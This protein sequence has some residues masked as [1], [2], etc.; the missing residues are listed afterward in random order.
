MSDKKISTTTPEKL[1]RKRQIRAQ[2]KLEGRCTRCGGK[3]DP[4]YRCKPCRNAELMRSYNMTLEQ[5]ETMSDDQGGCC[6]LCRVVF[7]AKKPLQRM[8]VDHNHRTGQ[9]RGLLCNP[10]NWFI[11]KLEERLLVDNEPIPENLEHIRQYFLERDDELSKH[12]LIRQY[13]EVS[14]R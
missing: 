6:V 7:N 14:L 2:W 10:C 1:T 5:R 3:L 13:S 4:G 12:E 8:E 9:I 11:G